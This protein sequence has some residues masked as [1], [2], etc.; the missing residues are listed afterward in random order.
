M[1]LFPMC[2]NKVSKVNPMND[3]STIN[4][5]MIYKTKKV[6]ADIRGNVKN[7]RKWLAVKFEPILERARSDL[8]VCSH[9][10]SI[11]PFECLRKFK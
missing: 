3:N 1:N 10:H 5:L 8:K 2:Q 11:D 7:Y 6:N 9:D 4:D